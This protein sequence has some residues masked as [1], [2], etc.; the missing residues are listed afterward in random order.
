MNRKAELLEERKKKWSASRSVSDLTEQVTKEASQMSTVTSSS[1][2]PLSPG[3]KQRGGSTDAIL[4]RLTD[5][6]TEHIRLE[7]QKEMQSLKTVDVRESVAEKMDS[8]LEAELSTHTCKI[9]FELMT[10]PVHTPILL[11]PCGHTFC[12]QCMDSHMGISG[13]KGQ[14]N[15]VQGGASS[16]TGKTCPY[17]RTKVESRAVNQSLKDLIDQ[18][19]KQKQMVWPLLSTLFNT[20]LKL[21]LQN[22]LQVQSHAVK[23]LEEVFPTRTSPTR[24]GKV[25]TPSSGS[26]GGRPS[27]ADYDHRVGGSGAPSGAVSHYAAQLKSCEMRYTILRNE[28]DDV[29]AEERQLNVKKTKINKGIQVVV[30]SVIIGVFS[31]S[32]W[33]WTVCTVVLHTAFLGQSPV[34]HTYCVI[35][36]S[37]A[38][39]HLQDERNKLG[40][41][42]QLLLEERDLIDR[43]LVEQRAKQADLAKVETALKERAALVGGTLSNLQVTIVEASSCALHSTNQFVNPLLLIGGDG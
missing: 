19:S 41:K 18:F 9:C 8:Y 4:H 30:N 14:P 6:L 7:L 5:K 37:T 40:A 29:A 33:W 10:S 23:H 25:G 16:S 2:A 21:N 43:H 11:F 39:E 20:V 24:V 31:M 28:L 22:T 34:S 15:R 27:T 13:S 3:G 32:Y 17:C 26:R 35:F 38:S 1:T 36:A 42:L 12:L